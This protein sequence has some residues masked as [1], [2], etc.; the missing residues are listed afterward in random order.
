[1]GKAEWSILAS[2][3]CRLLGQCAIRA[4]SRSRPIKFIDEHAASPLPVSWSLTT[5]GKIANVKVTF[6]IKVVATKHCHHAQILY[7]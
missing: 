5:G 4:H 7:A 3:L 2:V 1:M 6:L